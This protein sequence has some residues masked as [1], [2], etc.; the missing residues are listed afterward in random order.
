MLGADEVKG[1][2]NAV[3]S[4]VDKTPGFQEFRRVDV[5]HPLTRKE[6]ENPSSA[7]VTHRR[8][9]GKT[10]QKQGFWKAGGPE[11]HPPGKPTR[12]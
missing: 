4:S 11:M 6:T 8:I 7:N 1:Y 5:S 12:P 2:Q 3:I 9:K 10:P